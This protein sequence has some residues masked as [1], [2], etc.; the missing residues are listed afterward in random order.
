MRFLDVAVM[1]IPYSAA[2]SRNTAACRDEF[3]AT[4]TR[5]GQLLIVAPPL[6]TGMILSPAGSFAFTARAV[7]LCRRH[8]ARS[9]MYSGLWPAGQGEA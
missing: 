3:T 9:R 7:R 2:S 8:P 5:S 6:G 1:I 4:S